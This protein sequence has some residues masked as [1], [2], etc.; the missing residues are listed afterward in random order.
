MGSPKILKSSQTLDSVV[1][2]Y[3]FII[4]YFPSRRKTPFCY[5]RIRLQFIINLAIVKHLEIRDQQA[6]GYAREESLHY[7]FGRKA[8]ERLGDSLICYRIRIC[9]S[10]YRNVLIYST[11]FFHLFCVLTDEF[12]CRAR[13]ILQQYT[14]NKTILH[15]QL[16]AALRIVPSREPCYHHGGIS[17]ESTQESI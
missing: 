16:E 8:F 9:N 1:P 14:S 17:R 5:E 11:F 7:L 3:T 15:H 4:I 10:F 13:V 12:S 6:G 2:Y